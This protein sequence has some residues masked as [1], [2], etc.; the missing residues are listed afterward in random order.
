MTGVAQT[1]RTLTPLSGP[2]LIVVRRDGCSAFLPLTLR[3]AN[4]LGNLASTRRLPKPLP[5][6]VHALSPE[7]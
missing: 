1:G 2:T 3:A 4:Y 5:D 7:G 6:L